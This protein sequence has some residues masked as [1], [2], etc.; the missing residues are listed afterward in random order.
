[1][2]DYISKPVKKE[3][4]AAVLKRWTQQTR[5]EVAQSRAG[6][7]IVVL[8]ASVI[9]ELRGL[10]SASD[11]EFFSQVIDMFIADAPQRFALIRRAARDS[12][13]DALAREAH[14][15]KGSSAHLG[16]TRMA[17]LC[18]ILEEQGRSGTVGGVPSVL[19][20]LEEEFE[21]VSV[22]LSDEKKR[23]EAPGATAQRI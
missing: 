8:D 16:A 23:P 14:A 18:D 13:P 3:T 19:R 1:M 6:E 12:N 7:H 5:E 15:L 2:D 17:E 22:A 10:R 4:L 9:E 20:V 11:P 21:R